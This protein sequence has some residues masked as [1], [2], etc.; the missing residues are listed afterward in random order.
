[1]QTPKFKIKLGLP[2]LLLSLSFLV[3]RLAL[4]DS[5]SNTT[6]NGTVDQVKVK[7]CLIQSPIVHDIQTIVNFL[8]ASVGIIVVGVIILG[9]I[10]Y[11]LAG[12]NPQALK[13]ARDRIINGLIALLAFT[14]MFAFI[15]WLIPGGVFK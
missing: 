6:T 7:S 14:F 8:S 2:L 12:D 9:G 5:C 15:Q 13:A 4:A 11:T 3:P 10:Q 1:M